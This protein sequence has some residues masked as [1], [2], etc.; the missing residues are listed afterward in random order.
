MWQ[1]LEEFFSKLKPAQRALAQSFVEQTRRSETGRILLAEL[2][3]S[4][5]GNTTQRA[6]AGLRQ[7]K[8]RLNEEL[9]ALGTDIELAVDESGKLETRV[10][11]LRAPADKAAAFEELAD[12]LNYDR[13]RGK[14]IPP[15]ARPLSEPVTIEIPISYSHVN[16][17]LVREL[18]AR[19][20]V[21]LDARNLEIKYLLRRDEHD[22]KLLAPLGP[23][24]AAL[25]KTGNIA[26][27]ML[28]VDFFNS[29]YCQK[30]EV[31]K[32]I[33]P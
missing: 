1:V 7:T 20:Q 11:Y 31:P 16:K 22:T 26:L 4:H 17:R 13:D 6:L 15:K 32:F 8:K 12:T 27:F 28:S 24:I 9:A 23:Q 14:H 21:V 30:K 3:Q 5:F 19:L 29:N 10:C 2:L 25:F 33:D 18:H